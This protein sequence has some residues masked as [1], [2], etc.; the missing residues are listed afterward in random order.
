MAE[1]QIVTQLKSLSIAVNPLAVIDRIIAELEL[2]PTQYSDAVKSYEAVAVVLKKL[3]PLWQVVIFPQGSMR[4]GTT[5]R[6]IHE[7]CF[8][9]DMVCWLALSGK[10]Y[11][12][13]QIF[14]FVWDALG[15]DETYRQMRRK[16]NRC[17]RLEYADGRKYYLDVTPAVPDWAREKFLYVPDRERQS[18]CSSHPIGFCDDWFKKIAEVLPTIRRP[19]FLNNR[20]SAIVMANAATVEQMPEYGEF[21]KTPLQRIVQM[22]KRDRDE[23]FQDDPVHRPSSILLT[24]IIA[25]SYSSSV[26]Q[27]VRDLL[28]FVIKVVEKLPEYI[29]VV[30]TSGSRRFSVPNPVNPEENFAESWIEEHHRRFLIWHK[31]FATVLQKV[32]QSKGLGLGADEMLKNLAETF[33]N[34]RVIRAAKALGADTNALHDAGK[35]RA[36]AGTLGIVGTAVPKTIYFG[37]EK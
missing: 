11:T 1:H 35:L 17:I 22:L 13:E 18:W 32:H 23:H 9:L 7:E 34:D 28:E 25:K 12:P 20:S 31:R 21:E 3:H 8:D 29:E 19:L 2:T 10:L 33:G 14:N 16:K 15:Q 36:I 27:P 26:A 37:G 5:V 6:P 4:L 24:T 30:D